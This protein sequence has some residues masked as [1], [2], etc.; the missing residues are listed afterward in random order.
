MGKEYEGVLRTTF[1]IDTEGN[2]KHVFE[3]VRPAEHSVELLEKLGNITSWLSATSLYPPTL[4]PNNFPTRA[5]ASMASSPQKVTRKAPTHMFAPP[6]RAAIIPITARKNN[7][8]PTTTGIIR[9]VGAINTASK[10]SAAPTAK[11][12][13]EAKAA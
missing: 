6:S 13:A 3:N 12:K 11:D 5:V 10:G 2:V 1:L 4:V 7:E 8:L 9:F